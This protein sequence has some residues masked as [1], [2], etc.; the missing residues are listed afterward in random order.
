MTKPVAWVCVFLQLL[1]TSAQAAGTLK[2]AKSIQAPSS[3]PQI[4]RKLSDKDAKKAFGMSLEEYSSLLK[5]GAPYGVGKVIRKTLSDAARSDPR[6]ASEK[7]RLDQSGPKS[8]YS[9]RAGMN[10]KRVTPLENTPKE[11]G[12]ASIVR[13]GK[14]VTTAGSQMVAELPLAAV[15]LS[16][17]GA[18]DLSQ[19]VLPRFVGLALES[20]IEEND[21]DDSMTPIF[22]D[23]EGNSQQSIHYNR[24]A[25]SLP[26]PGTLQAQ[27][28]KTDLAYQKNELTDK[29]WFSYNINM[30]DF[31]FSMPISSSTFNLEFQD[32][33]EI[34]TSVD[35]GNSASIK[36]GAEFKL[37]DGLKLLVN[38]GGWVAASATALFAP[39]VAAFLAAILILVDTLEDRWVYATTSITD[40]RLKSLV[41]QV[42]RTEDSSILIKDI[43][44]I[45]F[46]LGQVTVI[47]ENFQ[48]ILDAI[49]KLFNGKIA[50]SLGL[51]RT[52]VASCTSLSDCVSD[53]A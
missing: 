35:I 6:Y 34:H 26:A 2:A 51:E 11:S 32:S 15:V 45:D 29:L 5:N 42:E 3:S 39:V 38:V 33:D 28:S 31:S 47:G 36:L 46:D 1:A 40:T 37:S 7:Q 21:L 12:S 9:I 18:Q 44:S 30:E 49:A 14:R 41:L 22:P 23:T 13:F 25:S 16:E 50:E 10:F 8:T 43:K 27:Q 24:S 19:T 52:K 4:G 17:Q 48:K 20:L 53:I